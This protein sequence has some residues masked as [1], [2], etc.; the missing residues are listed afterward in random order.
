[1]RSCPSLSLGL[2]LWLGLG[3]PAYCTAHQA[4]LMPCLMPCSLHCA[5]G[6]PPDDRTVPAHAHACAYSQAV[7]T[8][9]Y[10]FA[11]LLHSIWLPARIEICHARASL[12]SHCLQL[13]ILQG[14]MHYGGIPWSRLTIASTRLMFSLPQECMLRHETSG[15]HEGAMRVP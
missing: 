3:L 13:C 4:G 8:W 5:P 11:W 9:L 6:W 15:Y 2:G 7:V 1:M 10:R 12:I 14:I